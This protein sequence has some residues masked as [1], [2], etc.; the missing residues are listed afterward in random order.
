M[1]DGYW[2]DLIGVL[3]DDHLGVSV[4]P[5]LN[6][7][8]VVV[9]PG[10]SSSAVGEAGQD[11]SHDQLHL[12][13]RIV[14]SGLRILREVVSWSLRLP[15]SLLHVKVVSSN[16]LDVVPIGP[17]ESNDWLGRN[18][19][20]AELLLFPLK[21]SLHPGVLHDVDRLDGPATVVQHAVEVRLVHPEPPL[22][23]VPLVDVPGGLHPGDG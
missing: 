13:I 6:Q 7:L 20:L 4:S 1:E 23:V 15:H 8:G 18:S 3:N 11:L 17:V 5:D 12:V 2:K 19:L 9:G 10:E 21:L 14:E 22:Q 16:C